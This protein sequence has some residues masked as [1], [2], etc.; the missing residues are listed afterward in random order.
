MNSKTYL[1]KLESDKYLEFKTNEKTF[2]PTT[3]SNEFISEFKKFQKFE[4][5][6]VE[7]LDLEYG[8]GIV[9]IVLNHLGLIQSPLYASDLS[10]NAIEFAK[11]NCN[12]HRCN[13]IAKQGSIFSPW[14]NKKFDYI[15]NDI[16]GVTEGVASISPWFKNVPCESGADGTKLVTNVISTASK[17]LKSDG[18]LFFPVLSLSNADKILTSAKK[19]FYQVKKL[20][21]TE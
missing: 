17:Y 16:S 10:K 15:L 4:K 7:T 8:V 11:V 21:R 12:K 9:G 5:K 20:G 3:T 13:V 14:E 6:I 18:V 1:H 2:Y 19:Y